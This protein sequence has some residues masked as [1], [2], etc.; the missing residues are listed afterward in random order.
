MVIEFD[1]ESI[2]EK[3]DTDSNV[4]AAHFTTWVPIYSAQGT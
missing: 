1:S 2:P 3:Q 4:H